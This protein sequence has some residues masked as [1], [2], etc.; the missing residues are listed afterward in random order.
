MKTL[1][2][3]IK[4]KVKNLSTVQIILICVDWL[5]LIYNYY[6]VFKLIPINEYFSAWKNFGNGPSYFGEILIYLLFAP[7]CIL[8]INLAVKLICKNKVSSLI[9]LLI[10]N[11]LFVPLAYVVF[12]LF[13]TY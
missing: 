11:L 5:I 4:N 3:K 8:V 9:C 7:K 13:Y 10:I 6:F 2:N 1:I 12:F